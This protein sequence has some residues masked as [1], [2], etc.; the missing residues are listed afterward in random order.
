MSDIKIKT[1]KQHK[2]TNLEPKQAIKKTSLYKIYR[3][4]K[5]RYHRPKIRSV[6]L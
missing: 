3:P 4:L 1:S 2:Q 5:V 6:K